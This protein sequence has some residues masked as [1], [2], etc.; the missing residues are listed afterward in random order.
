M[1]SKPRRWATVPALAILAA[2]A[3]TAIG[4][5]VDQAVTVHFVY[6]AALATSVPVPDRWT[7]YDD[8]DRA[9]T[10][11]LPPELI[12]HDP[13]IR[14]ENLAGKKPRVAL[15]ARCLPLP[16]AGFAGPTTLGGHGG[17]Y[18]YMC[19]GGGFIGSAWVVLMPRS[20]GG[21]WRFAYWGA[22][23]IS[24]GRLAP[25]FTVILAAFMS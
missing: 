17:S 12:V 6:S 22:R 24:R 25:E 4:Q 15:S 9:A 1:A 18:Q 11:M 19:P 13:F 8:R 10:V 3:L 20:R 5:D 14:I 7:V 23:G 2:L 16:Q 21:T